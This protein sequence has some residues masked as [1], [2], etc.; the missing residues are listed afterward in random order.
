M[1]QKFLRLKEVRARVPFSRSTIYAKIR[2]GEFPRP[3]NLG[4]RAV[5]WVESD[6]DDWMQ[7]RILDDKGR[8]V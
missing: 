6:I 5:A 2:L 1:T 4:A 3:V 7:A 8:G